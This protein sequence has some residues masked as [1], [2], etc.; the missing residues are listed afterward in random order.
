M[1]AP[2][3]LRLLQPPPDVIGGQS[4]FGPPLPHT[5]VDVPGE[6]SGVSFENGAQKT[7]RPDG[8]VVIDFN[9]D[10]N[11]RPVDETDFYRNLAN[12]IDEGELAKI[13]SDL[14]TGIEFDENSRREWL[15]TR[16][17]AIKLLGL[18]LEE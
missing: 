9:P 18:K 12:E 15:D 4:P 11:K 2:T 10:A 16:Q 13:A 7:E 8:S 5:V 14:L 17:R 3:T 6:P 1:A